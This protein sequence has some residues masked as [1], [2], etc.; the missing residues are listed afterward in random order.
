M[1]LPVFV[2]ICAHRYSLDDLLCGTVSS[3]VLNGKTAW[4]DQAG[5][6]ALHQWGFRHDKNLTEKANNRERS[7]FRH[8]RRN[9]GQWEKLIV[10]ARR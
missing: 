5:G 3:L 4:G 6:Q 8:H 7:Q 9:S 10:T 1:Y 2:S